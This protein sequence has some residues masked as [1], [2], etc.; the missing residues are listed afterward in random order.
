LKSSPDQNES[1]KWLADVDAVFN[2]L[3]HPARRQILLAIHFRGGET[4]AGD[5]ARRF[6]HAWPTTTRH[7]NVLASAGL[8]ER[9]RSGKSVAYRLRYERLGLLGEWTAWFG[10]TPDGAAKPEGGQDG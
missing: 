3:A 1:V 2:A 8:L 7:L 10:K 5:I 4:T 9:R 6:A